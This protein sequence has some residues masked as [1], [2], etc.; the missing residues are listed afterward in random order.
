M[1]AHTHTHTHTHT[2]LHVFSTESSGPESSLDL[3]G[4]MSFSLIASQSR[5]SWE[6][7]CSLSG[8]L[9]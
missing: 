7:S 4:L 2:A 8:L 5:S 6:R 1:E 9:E 3:L